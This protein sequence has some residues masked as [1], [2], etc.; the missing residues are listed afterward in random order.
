MVVF[1][2]HAA[3]RGLDISDRAVTGSL[4]PPGLGRGVISLD[5]HA[6]LFRELSADPVGCSPRPFRAKTA[7]LIGPRPKYNLNG[8]ALHTQTY[9]IGPR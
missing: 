8:Q 5:P 1:Y 3:Q 7:T 6:L 9:L 2:S 4:Q